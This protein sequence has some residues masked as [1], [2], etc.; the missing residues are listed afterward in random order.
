MAGPLEHIT[1]W[2]LD[3]FPVMTMGEMEEVVRVM[4]GR[5][6]RR[7]VE[8]MRRGR[9]HHQEPAPG[10]DALIARPKL[11]LRVLPPGGSK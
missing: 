3:T 2:V 5:V 7:I 6:W 1:A 11:F 4:V 10:Q 8:E 9:P